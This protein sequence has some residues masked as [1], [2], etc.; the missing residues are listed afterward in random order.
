MQKYLMS[1]V[2]TGNPN[3]LWADDK[4]D[5]PLYNTSSAGTELVFNTTF[6]LED[7]NLANAKSLFWNKAMW[8]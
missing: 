5:W 6:Y 2:L 4:L 8:Y 7:D 3:T 1:F